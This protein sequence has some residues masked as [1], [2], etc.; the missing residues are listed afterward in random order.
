MEN[1]IE[2]VNDTFVNTVITAIDELVKQLKELNDLMG[3]DEFEERT[4]EYGYTSNAMFISY[5]WK[6]LYEY[7]QDFK[8]EY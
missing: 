1:T 3:P 2:S 4:L 7:T 8:L 5:L 6:G